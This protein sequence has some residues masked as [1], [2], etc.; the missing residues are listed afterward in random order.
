M[1]PFALLFAVAIGPNIGAFA[2]PMAK[3]SAVL[4][5][6]SQP[7]YSPLARQANIYGDVSLAVTVHPN[8]KTEVAFERGHPMLKQAALGSAQESRFECRECDSTVTFQLVYS[9]PL[10]ESNRE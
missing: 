1:R 5:E 7:V 9:F 2:Q 10:V 3:G 4:V 6:L 8:G